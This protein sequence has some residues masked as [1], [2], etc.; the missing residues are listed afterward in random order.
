MA[1]TFNSGRLAL[2]V[3][4]MVF[5]MAVVGSGCASS[6]RK[7]LVATHELVVETRAIPEATP[8]TLGR[9]MANWKR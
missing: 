5:P 9:L 1:G 8:I 7:D 2:V 4:G 6:N 3:M